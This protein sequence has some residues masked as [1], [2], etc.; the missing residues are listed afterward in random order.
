MTRVGQYESYPW[1]L[2]ASK[3]GQY[4]TFKNKT[5]NNMHT[6][7]GGIRTSRHPKASKMWVANIVLQKLETD[8]CMDQLI[9]RR[10]FKEILAFIF[11]TSKLGLVNRLLEFNYMMKIMHH[12]ILC[13]GMV[14]Q[15]LRLTRKVILTWVSR[16]MFWEGVY[17]F[18]H[19]LD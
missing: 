17:M 19:M 3:V 16:W 1:W 13:N 10:I 8:H 12:L 5:F 18:S 4:E 14:K 15:W 11:I 9:S 2:H 7:S 6:C